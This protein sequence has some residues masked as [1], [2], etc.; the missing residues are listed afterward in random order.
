MAS[1]IREWKW[2]FPFNRLFWIERKTSTY[3]RLNYMIFAS[4]MSQKRCTFH[5]LLLLLLLRKR[6]RSDCMFLL[7]FLNNCAA[8]FSKLLSEDAKE[9]V[10]VREIY[11]SQSSDAARHELICWTDHPRTSDPSKSSDAALFLL[12]FCRFCFSDATLSTLVMWD[13]NSMSPVRSAY[14]DT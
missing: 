8:N 9:K 6:S 13:H 14:V 12:L 10:K 1:S 11:L 3:P 7:K 5:L 4:L 2:G